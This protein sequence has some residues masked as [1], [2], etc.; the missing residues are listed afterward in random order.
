MT[1]H[2]PKPER[3]DSAFIDEGTRAHMARPSALAA[4]FWFILKNVL[5]W[6]MILSTPFLG[7]IPGPGGIV[8][9]IV[10][11][12]LVSF[13]GKRRVTARMLRGRPIPQD[14]QLFQ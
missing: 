9:F 1:P 14:S 5:G 12:G 2:G 11:F 13:P 10:G 7:P 8:L 3:R 4:W 6:L